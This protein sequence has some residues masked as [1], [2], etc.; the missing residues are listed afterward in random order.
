MTAADYKRITCA[1]CN[2]QL[3]P[4]RQ[5]K[6]YCG[7]A[8]KVAAWKTAHPVE[9]RARS[10]RYSANAASRV[11]T[12]YAG[13]C[14]GCGV[15]FTA[16]RKREYCSPNCHPKSVWKSI[17]PETKCCLACGAEYKPITRGGAPSDYCTTQCR[18]RVATKRKRIEK[19]KRRALIASVRVESVDPYKV[20][21]RDRWRCQMCGI[22]TP[23][24]K[25]GTHDDDAP[26]LDHIIPLARGGEH[27]YLNTQC[28][29]RGCNGTKS[30]RAMG[31]LLLL[32]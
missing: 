8:C 7:N 3:P 21:E 28:A 5:K 1:H 20:F 6:K 22:R 17:A 30:D 31:Q 19:S 32:G 18:D 9:H 2:N 24:A 25:R 26:E 27:S 16:R 4:S 13:Y 11:C 10:A 14:V 29:C 15:A 12:F 23:V